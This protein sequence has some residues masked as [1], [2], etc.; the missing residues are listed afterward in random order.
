MTT[1]FFKEIIKKVE[2]FM[3]MSNQ[4]VN[5]KPVLVSNPDLYKLRYDLMKEENEEYL[6]ACE[7]N[8]LVE[9]A[10]A[11][12]DQLYILVGT[13]LSHGMQ[14]KIEEVFQLIHENNSKK[15]PNGVCLFREDGKLIKPDGFEKVELSTIF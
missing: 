6:T 7:E 2:D 12:G 5:H 9:V 15:C 10:D 8:D 1:L 4:E 3:R 14:H 11:L 13:I